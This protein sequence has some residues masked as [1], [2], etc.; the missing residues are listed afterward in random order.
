MKIK[1]Y[2]P[3]GGAILVVAAIAA[4]IKSAHDEHKKQE[5]IEKIAQEKLARIYD[6]REELRALQISNGVMFAEALE[7]DPMLALEVSNINQAFFTLIANQ[8]LE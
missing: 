6:R 7:A 3:F 5:L 1:N 4:T 8:P 2:L